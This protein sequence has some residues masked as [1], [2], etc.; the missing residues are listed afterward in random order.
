MVFGHFHSIVICRLPY[1]LCRTEVIAKNR[2]K[3]G[4]LFFPGMR[5]AVITAN[6]NAASTASKLIEISIILLGESLTEE[7]RCEW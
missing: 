6:E 5:I 4:F 2:N 7:I 3:F 1:F